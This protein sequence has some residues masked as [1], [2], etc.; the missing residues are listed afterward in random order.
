MGARLVAE[1]L[2]SFD[3]KCQKSEGLQ[4]GSAKL[5]PTWLWL[6]NRYQNG[7]LVSGKRD[8]HLRNPS[9]LILRLAC[10]FFPTWP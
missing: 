10:C 6:K 4:L 5:A 9:W 1:H 2:E 3:D 8:Q 7:T